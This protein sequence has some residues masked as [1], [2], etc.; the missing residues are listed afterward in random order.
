MKK[1]SGKNLI[2]FFY[3]FLV[4]LVMAMPMFSGLVRVIYVQSNMNS[5]DSYYGVHINQTDFINV[6]NFQIGFEYSFINNGIDDVTY[7]GDGSTYIIA[8]HVT[9]DTLDSDTNYSLFF[10]YYDINTPLLRVRSEDN[11]V[12]YTNYVLRNITLNFTFNFISIS[13]QSTSFNAFKSSFYQIEYNTY[14]YL[15]NAFDY[16]IW[17]TMQD[18][19]FHSDFRFTDIANGMLMTFDNN[20]IYIQYINFYINWVL[21][22]AVI[23]FAPYVLLTFYHLA[24]GLLDKFMKKGED[25]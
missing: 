20:N 18:F 22:M 3:H 4:V 5:K 16:S 9:L 21:T 2:R 6:D 11:S 15:D 1:R 10:T 14:S 8:N 17:K 24:I 7:V 25:L 23:S 13:T 19:T 12:T